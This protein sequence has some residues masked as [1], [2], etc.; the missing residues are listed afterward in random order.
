LVSFKNLTDTEFFEAG[1][2]IFNEGDP[3]KE[4][5][6]IQEGEVDISFHH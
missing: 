1:E 2:T 3:G 5:F 6:V 4:M